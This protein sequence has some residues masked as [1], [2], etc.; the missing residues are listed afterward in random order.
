MCYLEERCVVPRKIGPLEKFLGLF[1]AFSRTLVVTPELESHSKENGE[2]RNTL[3]YFKRYVEK[4]TAH[5]SK[6]HGNL[7]R[8]RNV[9]LSIKLRIQYTGVKTLFK[10]LPKTPTPIVRDV[11]GNAVPPATSCCGAAPLV[12]RHFLDFI[13]SQ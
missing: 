2:K 6:D 5:C 13:P 4:K 12:Q 7:F 9:S 1:H 8:G 3:T 11:S 10:N